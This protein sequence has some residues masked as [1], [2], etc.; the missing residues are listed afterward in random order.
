MRFMLGGSVATAALLVPLVTRALP[1]L[2]LFITFL[3]INAEV[4]E[5]SA[6]LDG[7]VLSVA[8]VAE[9]IEGAAPGARITVDDAVLPL[10]ESVDGASF[11]ALHGGSLM[12]PV[13]ERVTGS[14]RRFEE[15]LAAGLVSV[16]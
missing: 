1:L 7:A 2:L 10:V 9:L 8:E 11:V 13:E 6:N 4:W 3:F 14:V 16:G 15:L 12:G 5:L